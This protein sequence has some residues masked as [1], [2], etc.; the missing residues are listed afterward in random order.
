[1][2]AVLVLHESVLTDQLRKRTFDCVLI[3]AGVRAPEQLLLFEKLQI[4]R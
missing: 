4:V 2:P 1:M 3:G